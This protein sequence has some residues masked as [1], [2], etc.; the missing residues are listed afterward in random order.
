ME[1]CS[2][3]RVEAFARMIAQLSPASFQLMEDNAAILLARDRIEQREKEK[4][5]QQ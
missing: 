5:V 3:A 4:V 2:D 1:K